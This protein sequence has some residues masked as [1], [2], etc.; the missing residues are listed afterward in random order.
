M[1]KVANRPAALTLSEAGTPANGNFVVTQVSISRTSI[2]D[3]K[4]VGHVL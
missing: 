4:F 3:E 1:Q 2:S